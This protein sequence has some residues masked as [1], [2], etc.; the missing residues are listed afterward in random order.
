M[1]GSSRDSR[2]GATPRSRIVRQIAYPTLVG[3]LLIG[4]AACSSTT[5]PDVKP[6]EAEIRITG[7]MPDSV[8]LI[9]S[10]D[11]FE[12]F[13]QVNGVRNQVFNT[14]DTLY[15]TSLPYTQTVA[16]TDLGSVVVD[17]S[18]PFDDPA[19]VRLFVELD[20]GQPPYD[21]EAMMSQGGALR[22]VFAYFSPTF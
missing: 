19:T 8:R 4:V 21:R 10:T 14:A 20:S 15:V 12:T 5:D 3:A 17:V 7:T 18:N 9:I 16:L 11:F 6:T 22:Y 2:F 1:S 13:D